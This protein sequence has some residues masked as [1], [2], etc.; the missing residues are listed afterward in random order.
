MSIKTLLLLFN[1]L[2]STLK[3]N[4]FKLFERR[5]KS[6]TDVV[7]VHIFLEFRE[8]GEGEKKQPVRNSNRAAYLNRG[9]LASSLSLDM[10]QTPEMDPLGL[11]I[12]GCS[13]WG[14][15]GHGCL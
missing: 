7:F 8:T 14:S 9:L 1:S 11:A 3:Q 12:L 13:G 10:L 15:A 6:E 2:G 5:P 4:V